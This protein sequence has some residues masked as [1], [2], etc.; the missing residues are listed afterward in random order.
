MIEN[1]TLE[2]ISLSRNFEL[3]QRAEKDQELFKA[4]VAP[5]AE[6]TYA[7]ASP[8]L[9][10]V[11]DDES[12]K[13][14]QRVFLLSN[15]ESPRMVVFSGAAHGDGCTTICASAAQALAAQTPGSV[16]VV[17]ANFRRPSLH[18]RFNL[19]S[20]TGLAE[21]LVRSGPVRSFAQQL[22]SG[23]IW[24]FSSGSI[25]TNSISLLASDRLRSRFADLRSEF[26]YVLIDVPPVGL[27][28]DAV[29]LGQLADGVVLVVESNS[30]RR[31]TA[32][33]AKEALEGANVRMLGAVLNKRTFPIP[34]I[35]YRNL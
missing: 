14:V 34:E 27:Y 31:E 3:L 5:A 8:N 29:L 24:V 20:R 9:E 21:A 4:Y 25:E 28:S 22:G 15:S 33:K 12:I 17:D 13:L 32:R 6:P 19:E 16:C 10:K 1:N 11:A 7:P 30:T 23:N 18:R 2:G 26:D 35:L